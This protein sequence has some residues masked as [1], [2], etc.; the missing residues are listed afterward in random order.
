MRGLVRVR[1]ER[2]GARSV[3]ASCEGHVPLA[4]RALGGREGWARVSLVQTV[5]GLLS[6]DAVEIELEVGPRAALELTATAATVAYPAQLPASIQVSCRVGAE[7]RLAWLPEPTVLAA[8]CDLHASMEVELAEGAAAVVRETIVLGRYGEV[9]GRCDTLLRCDLAG[10]P[11]LRDRVRIDEASRSSPVGL[12]GAGVFASLALL[13]ARPAQEPGAGELDLAGEGRL[14]R[15][16]ANDAAEA[17][18]RRRPLEARYLAELRS[19]DST[20]AREAA[21]GQG[22]DEQRARV[23]EVAFGSTVRSQS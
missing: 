21:Q 16:L 14:L 8:G 19:R 9:S 7:G 10:R 11:L 18:Q 22:S 2:R 3:L 17:E 1:V 12:D 13:G 4:P 6:G 5:A 20:V 23:P 15:L